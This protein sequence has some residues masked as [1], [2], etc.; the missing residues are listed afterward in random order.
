MA[1]PCHKASLLSTKGS[2]S[3]APAPCRS[4][5]SK[6]SEANV[7]SIRYS[8][9]TTELRALGKAAFVL[10][11]S[12]LLSMGDDGDHPSRSKR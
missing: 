1:L 9:H 5:D 10:W 6:A 12:V 7:A 2:D 3:Q 8:F 4:S 11:A